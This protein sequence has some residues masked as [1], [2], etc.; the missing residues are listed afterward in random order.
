MITHKPKNSFNRARPRGFTL[1]EVLVA[2]LVLSIGLL[3]LA[4]LQTTSL[5]YNTDS[6]FRTQATLLAYDIIDRMRTNTTGLYAGNYDAAT[7]AAAAAKVSAY[8]ACKASGCRCDVSTAN[9]STSS[10]A[11]YDLGKWYEK[12][13]AVL[14]EGSTNLATVSRTASNMVTIT[15][16]WK[17]R[18]ILKNHVWEVQL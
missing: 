12:I 1:I 8:D 3:G 10:L 6:Y 7:S 16:Q 4:A 5:K 15:I 18:D 11:T 17:E 14:P 2:L 13:S 9:C